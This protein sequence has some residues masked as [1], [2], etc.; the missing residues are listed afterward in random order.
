M[1]HYVHCDLLTYLFT[2]FGSDGKNYC[3]YMQNLETHF[4][5]SGL[6]GVSERNFSPRQRNSVYEKYRILPEII[7]INNEGEG[8]WRVSFTEGSR[9]GRE[10]GGRD[11]NGLKPTQF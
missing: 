3:E 7:S 6:Q 9:E 8:K 4:Q 1:Q 10:G 5:C 11:E 2:Y